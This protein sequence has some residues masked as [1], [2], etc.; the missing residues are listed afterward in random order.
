MDA[1][2]IRSA[3]IVSGNGSGTAPYPVRTIADLAK[4]RTAQGALA[5]LLPI[6]VDVKMI[7]TAGKEPINLM[8]ATNR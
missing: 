4:A 8:K 6:E 2:P 7:T 1:S 5:A 3:D